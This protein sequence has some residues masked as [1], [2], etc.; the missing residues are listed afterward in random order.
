MIT[1]G[2]SKQLIADLFKAELLNTPQYQ[3]ILT[4]KQI[5]LNEIATP[6]VQPSIVY[7]FE[8]P[9][10]E[11]DINVINMCMMVEFGFSTTNISSYA[12][13][14]NMADFLN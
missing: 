11:Y 3:I 2:L 6:S 5:I 14:I 12:V 9:Q 13:V 4:I 7:N 10:T 1:K 8:T